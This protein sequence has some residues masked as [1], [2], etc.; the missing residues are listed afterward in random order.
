MVDIFK[1]RKFLGDEDIIDC[2]QVLSVLGKPNA[3]R[4]GN[5]WNP[6]PKCQLNRKE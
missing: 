6:K 2:A 5:H 3:S 4:M 1:K